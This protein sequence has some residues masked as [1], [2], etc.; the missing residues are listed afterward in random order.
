[1]AF[2][3]IVTIRPADY[4][5]VRAFEEIR[6]LLYHSL[7]ELGHDVQI[8]SN[9]YDSGVINIILGSH[10][11]TAEQC[12][13]IPE[14]SIIFNT[15]QMLGDYTKWTQQ[16]ADLAARHRVWDYS[17]KNIEALRVGAAETDRIRAQRL[18]LG[19]HPRLERLPH[20]RSREEGLVF[21]GSVTPLRL[22]CL[23]RLE[24]S[25]S[26][27]LSVYAGVYGWERDGILARSLACLNLH[28]QEA[29]VLEWPRILYLLANRVPCIAL[30]HP[31]TYWEDQ[32]LSYL[33]CVDEDAPVP[34]IEA[35][36]TDPDALQ[37]SAEEAS[38]RFKEQERQCE[39]TAAA[40]EHS[41]GSEFI[42]AEDQAAPSTHELSDA[43]PSA[44]S[45]EVDVRWYRHIYPAVDEDPRGIVDY[46]REEGLWR[47]Y[48]PNPDFHL[49]FREPL[50][51]P[52]LTESV[53]D[54]ESAAPLPRGDSFRCAVVLHFHSVAMAKRFF[55]DFGCHLSTADFFVTSSS[56]FVL[57]VVRNLSR[58]FGVSRLEVSLLKNIG[59]DIPS[60]YIVFN[61]LLSGYD[62]CLF[63][64]GK[65][66]DLQWFHDHNSILAGS[67]ARVAEIQRLF[68][69]DPTLGIVFPDYLSF[70][71]PWIGW[72]EMRPMVDALLSRFG[73]DTASIDLLEF[74]AG[75]FFW[76]RPQALS[77]I[78]ALDFTMADLPEEPLAK[79]Q[80]LLHALERLPCISCEMMGLEWLKISR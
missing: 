33:R 25:A 60:K 69:Q 6:L 26:L 73:C 32:Q 44:D 54:S 10:L 63:S 12:T 1:M 64:H 79:N 56:P 48:H 70:Y 16:I 66:S 4:P 36:L 49:R 14:G 21:F 42:P 46:H 77:I 80:T 15:E 55:S 39:F 78:S 41:F 5:H 53:S 38:E 20:E 7:K 61:Q 50:R 18:R 43:T 68:L 30:I 74:P 57:A 8:Y 59:R 22:T 72:G 40:L 28:S 37:H 51:F 24:A 62:L 34:A 31:K 47:Q 58:E 67:P 29:R 2:F 3:S 45:P 75:G 23:A 52:S 76:A 65:E 27:K 11:L 17:Y 13:E 9:R 35:I 71:R 19:Y